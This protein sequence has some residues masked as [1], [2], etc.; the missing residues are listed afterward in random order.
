MIFESIQGG[1]R[2]RLN[3]AGVQALDDELNGDVAETW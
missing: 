1:F 3:P 2:L